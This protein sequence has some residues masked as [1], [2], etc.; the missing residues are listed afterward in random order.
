MFRLSTFFFSTLFFLLFVG[1]AR[2]V[3]QFHRSFKRRRHLPMAYF[4]CHVTPA[5]HAHC[6]A[7]VTGEPGK[8]FWL[9]NHGSTRSDPIR[10]ETK[11]A[12]RSKSNGMLSF[13]GHCHRM[14]T[15]GVTPVW[16]WFFNSPIQLPTAFSTAPHGVTKCNCDCRQS[17]P[18]AI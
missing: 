5:A 3:Q 6:S 14:Q 7:N 8:T 1:H 15:E 2:H 9:G 17:H 4:I 18:A 11:R 10:N 13:K 12:G 16:R